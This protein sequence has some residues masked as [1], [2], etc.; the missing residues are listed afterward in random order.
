MTKIYS[1]NKRYTGVIAGVSFTNG[2]GET[3]N[4][5]LKQWFAEKG[6]TVEDEIKQ[7]KTFDEMTLSELKE[8]AKE[9][10]LKGYS[11]LK[12]SELLEALKG[13]GASDPVGTTETVD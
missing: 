8:S 4:D 7:P 2:V 13:D 3:N 11:V 10:G 9:K 5:W 12:K 6:Y 1:P